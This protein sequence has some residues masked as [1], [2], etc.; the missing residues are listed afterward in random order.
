MWSHLGPS[1]QN[2]T[3]LNCVAAQTVA[4][5]SEDPWLQTNLLHAGVLW[6]LVLFVFQYDYTLDEGGV[7]TSDETN[8]QEV[9][10]NL[11]RL[12]IIAVA[13]LAGFKSKPCHCHTLSLATP[14]S[15]VGTES[16]TPEN[17]TIQAVIRTLFTPFLTKC[18]TRNT[19][20]EVRY[21]S[22]H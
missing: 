21:F 13:K 14:L 9:A 19:T 10:N 8:Q 7:E 12:S 4:A 11:A 17:R 2:L 1:P 15:A 6:H 16:V 20:N 3:R 22:S 18:I 5:F